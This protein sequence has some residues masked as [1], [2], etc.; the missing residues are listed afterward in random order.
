M[1]LDEFHYK[2]KFSDVLKA[3]IGNE[4]TLAMDYPKC[5]E[6]IGVTDYIKKPNIL[7]LRL[8]RYQGPINKVSIKPDESLDVVNIRFGSTANFVHEI[9]QVKR[10]GKWYEINDTC[11]YEIKNISNFDCSYGLFYKKKKSQIT[12]I[13]YELNN[14]VKINIS[15][16]K[17][18]FTSIWNFLTSPLYLLFSK[19]K[20]DLN[21][22]ILSGYSSYFLL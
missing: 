9:C 4:N 18:W 19:E 11:G 20:N 17:N 6:E 14:I 21:Y 1:Y 8:E 16:S 3:N 10:K 13:N 22:G 15:P 12:E 5:N 2:F 7:I